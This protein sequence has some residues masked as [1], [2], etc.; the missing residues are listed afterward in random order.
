[1]SLLSANVIFL[2]HFSKSKNYCLNFKTLLL[3]TLYLN[4]QWRTSYAKFSVAYPCTRTCQF[5][6][7]Y[8][9]SCSCLNGSGVFFMFSFARWGLFLK[10]SP[11]KCL[12]E[13][14]RETFH[15]RVKCMFIWNTVS[16]TTITGT[17]R[18]P[19]AH[20]LPCNV[21]Y[22]PLSAQST[23][24]MCAWTSVCECVSVCVRAWRTAVM[25]R[26]EP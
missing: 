14:Y 21:C 9:S 4:W 12:L 7:R 25:S 17:A 16:T 24:S 6:Y 1:M 20:F 11:L 22:T 2:S 13:A 10:Y 5:C 8:H 19:T 26:P 23:G 18:A 15:I 3:R